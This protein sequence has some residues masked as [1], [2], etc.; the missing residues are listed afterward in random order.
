MVRGVGG[1]QRYKCA[2]T[3]STPTAIT[4]LEED[5]DLGL[6]PTERS[7]P[8]RKRPNMEGRSTNATRAAELRVV[9]IPSSSA[10]SCTT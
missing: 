4:A 7:D 10:F 8:T 3:S 9:C 5:W 6:G 1:A 2:P